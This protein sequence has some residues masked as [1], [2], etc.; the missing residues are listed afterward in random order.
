MLCSAIN[1]IAYARPI[2]NTAVGL[3]RQYLSLHPPETHED[4]T[5]LFNTGQFVLWAD[6]RG[7]AESGDRPLFT[8][9]DL[10]EYPA[11]RTWLNQPFAPPR[12]RQARISMVGLGPD[13]RINANHIRVLR[14][15]ATD[16]HRR[17]LIYLSCKPYHAR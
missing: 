17:E 14:A 2:L 12:E 6:A 1:S 5:D 16:I 3:F 10:D 11:L 8:E 7:A 15:F 4:E 9:E 13:A